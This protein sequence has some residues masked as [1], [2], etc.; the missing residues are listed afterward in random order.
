MTNYD[1]Y[2]KEFLIKNKEVSLEKIGKLSLKGNAAINENDIAIQAGF[3]SFQYNRKAE[4]TPELVTFITEKTGKNKILVASDIESY[5]EQARQFINIGRPYEMEGVAV[6]AINNS[7][8]YELRQDDSVFL[9]EDMLTREKHVKHTRRR[10]AK[11]GSGRKK[12]LTFFAFLII[13]IVLGVIGW[14]GYTMF[15]EKSFPWMETDTTTQIIAP[16]TIDTSHTVQS[17]SVQSV[18]IK[19]DSIMC[20]YI[21]ETTKLLSRAQNRFAQ[22]K[23]FGD[24]VEMDTVRRDTTNIYHLFYKMKRL[25]ADTARVRDSLQKY[26]QLKV[27]I[28]TVNN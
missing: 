12:V 26:L 6:I 8:D 15:I 7:G 2:I 10:S 3:L 21:F 5:L 11:R 17:P 9:G 16:A 1:S 28:V 24:H 25:P 4:T 19:S 18:D 22:L 13:I 20:K 27:R 14:G 23:S